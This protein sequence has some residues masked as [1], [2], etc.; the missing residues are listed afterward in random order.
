VLT[1]LR[2]TILAAGVI[3]GALVACPARAA[4]PEGMREPVRLTVGPSDQYLG[5]LAPN[6]HDLYFVSNENATSQIFVQDLRRGVARLVFEESADATWPRV[7]PDGKTLLYVSYQGDAAGDVCLRDIETLE[8]RCLTDDKSADVQAFW[9]HDGSGV[10][11]VSREGL[12][13]NHRLLRYAAS[14]GAPSVLLARNVSSPDLSPDGRWIAY[15][16]VERISQ[17]VGVSFAVR[18]AGDLEIARLDAASKAQ[19]LRFSLPGISGFPAFSADGK[20]L[21]FSQY[22]NDTNFDGAIDGND[23]SVIFRAPFDA[24]RASPVDVERAEQLTS[25]MW[26]CQYPSPNATRLI[27]TC[28]Y[29]G[30]LDVY[31]LPLDGSVPRAWGRDKVADAIGSSRIRWERLLLLY[32]LTALE[33]DA[34]RDAEI[35]RE[36]T[37]LH[38]GLGEFESATY[39]ARL[40]KRLFAKDAARS[41]WATVVLE[42][43]GHRREERALARGQLGERFVTSARSRLERLAS[44]RSGPPAVAALASLATSEIHDAI[45]DVERATASLRA[46]DAKA[47]GDP[48]V[49][50]ALAERAEIWAR[51]FDDVEPLLALY[52]ALS[53]H[54]ALSERDRL[55]FAGAHIRTLVRGLPKAQRKARVEAWRAKVDPYSE[56]GF[57]LDLERHLLPLSPETQ[58]AVR[59]GVFDLYRANHGFERRRTLVQRTLR[60][61]ARED[62]DY[63]L[64]EFANTWV[65]WLTRDKAERRHAELLYRQVVLERAYIQLARGQVGDARGHF[66]GVTLQTDS[67]EAHVGFIEGRYAEGKAR[68]VLPLYEK[69]FKDKPDDAVIRFVRAWLL[70]R[71]LVSVQDPVAH[72][73]R[74]ADA[75]VHLQVALA[76][77]PQSAEL[78]HLWAYLAHQ[79]FLRGGDRLTAVE[80]NTHYLLALDLARDNPRYQASTLQ[81]VAALQAEVGNPLLALGYLDER[82]KLPFIDASTEVAHRSAKARAL[83]HGDRD[84]EAATEMEKAITLV[85]KSPAL[86]RFRPL[87]VDRAAL[88]HLAAG[89]Y[90]KACARYDEAVTAAEASREGSAYNRLSARLGR[91][92]ARI[93]AGQGAAALA[94]LVAVEALL[95]GKETLV[96]PRA[97]TARGPGQ[98]EVTLRE[99]DTLIV[100]GLRAQALLL[101]GDLEG[102]R[103]SMSK[104]RDG[105]GARLDRRPVDEDRLA[106]AQAEAQLALL[107]WKRKDVREARDRL[108]AALAAWDDY[109]DKTGTEVDETGLALLRAYVELHLQ[110]GLP[111]AELRRDP[112]GRLETTFKRLSTR[113]NPAWEDT[114]RRFGL[115]LVLLR[116]PGR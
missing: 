31:A 64:Y 85:E 104:R 71:D 34:S 74:I 72:D 47:I 54:E 55:A 11:V 65:S 53:S 111:L 77:A 109:A 28:V 18:A 48:F 97:A 67:L 35:Y 8:R 75:L 110:G 27:V 116:L 87:L 84:A 29:D 83:Y 23:H 86:A 79:R 13:G 62:N 42:L 14:G 16:P 4:P 7:S 60:R 5:D 108:E 113:R 22:I 51:R 93:G 19:R 30:S 15:V 78:H 57:V 96:V 49:L 32:R 98:D 58:E 17:T 52:Q 95:A 105:L 114:R 59:K 69:R 92:G 45:G 24:A 103:A 25:A 43:V 76:A 36:M 37:R 46:V 94:D 88:Y 40:V 68:E 56:L 26:N 73:K 50:H 39:Y 70:A 6:G 9:L 100:H 1:P 33:E 82:E 66:Y 20:W 99:D 91:A 21:Y 89:A 101:T 12:H 38:L 107:A 106:L 41:G 63:L 112:R 81:G 90:L 80:A 10:V 61:A 3:A 2:A 115:Y 44:L 102:A